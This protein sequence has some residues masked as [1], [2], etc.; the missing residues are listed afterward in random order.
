MP[1]YLET[2]KRFSPVR[3]LPPT[4]GPGFIFRGLAP[5]DLFQTLNTQLFMEEP[6]TSAGFKLLTKQ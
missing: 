3:E 5:E 6:E 1:A 4:N 2:E